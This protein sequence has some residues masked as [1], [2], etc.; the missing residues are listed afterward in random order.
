MLL[1]LSPLFSM[2]RGQSQ[3]TQVLMDTI[4]TKAAMGAHSAADEL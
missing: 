2:Q 3:A 1:L 4:S